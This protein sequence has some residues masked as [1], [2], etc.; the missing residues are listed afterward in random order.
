MKYRVVIGHT[1]TDLEVLP[2]PEPLFT[3][4]M[5]GKTYVAEVQHVDGAEIFT[6]LVDG[7]SWEFL[8][9]RQGATYTIVLQGQSYSARVLE[10]ALA[11]MDHLPAPAHAVTAAT[12]TAA[13]PGVVVDVLV[14]AGDAVTQGATLVVIESMK[15]NNPIKAP[16]DGTVKSVNVAKGQRVNKGD[17]LAVLE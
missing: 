16:R 1:Q 5:D 12:L 3:V 17:V 7:Q 15:M 8:A 6:L 4:V 13:M 9:Q 14:S 2:G 11:R 10:G